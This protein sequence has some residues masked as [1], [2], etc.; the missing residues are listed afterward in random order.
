MYWLISKVL[1]P[2]DEQKGMMRSLRGMLS[3]LGSN[4]EGVSAVYDEAQGG[5]AR[6]GLCWLCA[7]VI[8]LLGGY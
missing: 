2:Q 6:V 4:E 7:V 5:L 8:P 3:E 1:C